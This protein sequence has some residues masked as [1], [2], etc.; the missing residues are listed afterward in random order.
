MSNNPF[1]VSK[2]KSSQYYKLL[3]IYKL[4]FP[5]KASKVKIDFNLTNDELEKTYILAFQNCQ[6]TYVKDFQYRLLNYILYLNPLLYKIGLVESPMC[7]F[8]SC[9]EETFYH[10]FYE[11]QISLSFWKSFETFWKMCSNE[12]I[13]LSLRQIYI[14]DFNRKFD[15]LNYCILLGKIYLYS[16]RRSKCNPTLKGF[17]NLLKYKG[18]WEHH[19]A[20]ENK[21]VMLFMIDGKN[22]SPFYNFIISIDVGMICDDRISI[23]LYLC[24][25][26][27]L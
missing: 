22:A 12:Q 1:E 14:G 19:I 2:A 26:F 5:R 25:C 17:Q 27:C 9:N 13:H 10:F 3:L 20:K 24:D 16:C 21:V 8:C 11:C 7:S 6:E 4:Q 15:L 23:C 18:E